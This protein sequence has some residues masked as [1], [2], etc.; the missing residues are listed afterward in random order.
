MQRIT[1]PGTP[2]VTFELA[3][4][5]F[6]IYIIMAFHKY[7]LHEERLPNE[8]GERVHAHVHAF[9]D[10]YIQKKRKKK[11]DDLPSITYSHIHI[12]VYSTLVH[13]RTHLNICVR[14]H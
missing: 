8:D 2:A 3:A 6:R 10:V 7:R 9:T 11:K 1:S 5:R 13:P 12:H 14:T 4:D